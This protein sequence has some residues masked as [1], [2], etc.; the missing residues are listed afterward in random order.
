MP[1]YSIPNQVKS[2]FTH[3]ISLTLEE[4]KQLYTA[5]QNAR[6]G[7][8]VK[9]IAKTFSDNSNISESKAAEIVQSLLSMVHLLDS[10]EESTEVFAKDFAES[11][12]QA[13]RDLNLS[14]EDTQKFAEALTLIIPTFKGVRMTVKAK[15]L[16]SDNAQ[17]YSES[18]I[19]SDIRIVYDED[20]KKKE[21]YAVVVHQLRIKHFNE[22]GPTITHVSLD[23]S[24]LKQLQEVVNR[25]IEKDKLIR[26]EN[27]Q[28][29]FVNV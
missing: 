25:A 27:Y 21:Q 20:L 5:I 29:A 8:G 13:F 28:I 3:L 16:I 11:F 12:K 24:D 4:V 23:L 1:R 2:G 9:Q 7:E 15:E 22:T 26:E 17:N 6:V 19:I 18:R 14:G 10:S